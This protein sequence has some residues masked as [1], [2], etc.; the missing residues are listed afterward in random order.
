MWKVVK[1]KEISTK[2]K[3]MTE[4]FKISPAG[5]S[6]LISWLILSQ[7]QIWW[8][9]IHFLP[10][11]FP[12]TTCFIMLHVIFL[13]N[14]FIAQS[15]LNNQLG[16]CPSLCK[17]VNKFVNYV[18]FSVVPLPD[19]YFFWRCIVYVYGFTFISVLNKP[20]SV[21]SSL[22]KAL[23]SKRYHKWLAISPEIVTGKIAKNI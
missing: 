10:C 22:Y 23:S 18:F 7:N 19:F 16:H 17:M 13:S 21:I 1:V 5:M 11:N 14:L 12:K 2:K 9:V 15:T 3:I 20:R 4:R 6:I 8:T